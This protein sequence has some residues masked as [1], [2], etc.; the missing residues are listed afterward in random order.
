MSTPIGHFFPIPLSPSRYDVW[1]LD[2]EG[3][4]PH[5]NSDEEVNGVEVMGE[6]DEAVVC[7]ITS[8]R[9]DSITATA[10]LEWE[11]REG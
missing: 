7:K 8:C 9:W 10:N 1:S 11:R 4:L 6:E 2:N 5:P 3:K